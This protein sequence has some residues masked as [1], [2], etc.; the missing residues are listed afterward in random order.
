MGATANDESLTA[1]PLSYIRSDSNQS[2][3]GV[4]IKCIYQRQT[5][6]LDYGVVQLQQ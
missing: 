4:G 2:R 6:I 5:F 1:T 3:R